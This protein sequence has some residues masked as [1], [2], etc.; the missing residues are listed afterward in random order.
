MLTSLKVVRMA[1][2]DCDCT[3]RSAMRWRSRDIGT[4]CSVR[5]PVGI[6]MG[7]G[8]GFAAAGSVDISPVRAPS[9]SPLVTRPSRP[10]P[11]TVA[12]SMPF[13]AAIFAADGEAAFAA[14]GA[15]AGA[16]WAP[17]FAGV[18]ACFSA[19]GAGTLAVT[20][21]SVSIVA[22]TSPLVTLSPS[23]LTIFASTPS[24]GA[25]S[26]S[27]TLSVSTSMRFSSRFTASPGFLR[28][29][30]SVASEI[31]SDS[32]GTFTSTCMRVS[33]FSLGGLLL[34]HFRAERGVDEFL[35]L[36]Q[37]KLHVAH[38][39]RGRRRAPR[40]LEVLVGAQVPQ[41][42]MLDAVP[43]ALV[44]GLFLAPHDALRV[45][46]R[47]DLRL[48]LVVREGV[49][50]L[51]A[52]DRDVVI[53]LARA[54]DHA[55]HL[56]RRDLLDLGH[57]HLE[58]GAAREVR[59]GRGRLLLAQQALRRHDDE[60][61]AHRPHDLAA[62][63]VVVLR[64]RRG[65]ADL[66]VVLGAELQVAL[67]AR[68]RVLRTLALV[69]VR[70][71]HREAAEPPPFRLARGDELVDHDLRAVGEVAELRFPDD[72]LVRLRGRV[73]VLEAEHR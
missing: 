17:A 29:A 3:S 57:D 5:S 4:R 9:T 24:A 11:C 69:A 1:A 71:E 47:V 51:E 22:M 56:L 43:R 41:Q 23:L 72:E 59:Q 18:T 37:V 35:L 58:G 13:S 46:I 62:D 31:D 27:T 70:Q 10:V 42:V 66:D 7:N 50:L 60:G 32:C 55:L 21:A 26:S 6:W 53:H 20:F 30:T 34:R 68:R 65:H 61:L 64:R 63:H 33:F 38:R 52:H 45:R 28:H 25:G 44:A 12:V 36:L 49:E 39:G 67:E 73:A 40:V 19:A 54:E 15:A 2:V 8:A 16:P 48:E 14:A